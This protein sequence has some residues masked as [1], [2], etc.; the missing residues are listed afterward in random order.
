MAAIHYGGQNDQISISR[1]T[2]GSAGLWDSARSLLCIYD[3][4]VKTIPRYFIRLE[5]SGLQ[6]ALLCH[7]IEPVYLHSIIVGSLHHTGHLAR[8]MSHRMEA[9]ASC[10]PHTGKNRPLLSGV[11]NTEARQPGKS[12]HFSAN[13]IVGSADLEIINATTGKRSCGGSSRLCKHV[14]SARW[15]RLHGRLS[16]RIPG[17]GETPSMY[18][19]AKLGAH[20]YQS[21]KQQLFKAFQRAGLG[22]WVRKPPE[23]D[24]FLLSL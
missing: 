5:C 13:W 7:F 24:Q 11:S 9:S 17:Q 21:V 12:P 18:C 3:N 22:T 10:L 4:P 19:E 16:T 23:Q 8:V 20:T 6:G 14:F 2:G 1:D 15:A